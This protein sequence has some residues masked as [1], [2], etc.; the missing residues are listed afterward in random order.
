LKTFLKFLIL[1]IK[2]FHI[3]VEVM[4]DTHN[5]TRTSLIWWMISSYPPDSPCFCL[6]ACC[7]CSTLI[8][9]TSLP[10]FCHYW[11]ELPQLLVA[12]THV[13]NPVWQLRGV[14]SVL[15]H[16]ICCESLLTAVDC[17]PIDFIHCISSC[18]SK[19]NDI[20]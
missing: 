12:A 13:V 10:F 14:F 6:K 7:R 17:A 8:I 11:K 5:L 9:T 16:H 20:Q 18:K 2:P 19:M 1:A 4:N 15:A 3:I